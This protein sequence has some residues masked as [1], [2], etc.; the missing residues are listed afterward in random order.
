MIVT[1]RTRLYHRLRI[2]RGTFLNAAAL[3]AL[4]WIVVYV[5]LS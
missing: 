1:W 5:A 3:G 4:T 2:Q